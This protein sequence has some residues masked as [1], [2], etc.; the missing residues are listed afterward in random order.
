MLARDLISFDVKPLKTSDS[1]ETALTRMSDFNIRHLPI[2]NDQQLLGLVSEDDILNEDADEPVGSYGLSLNRPY[3]DEF[4]HV[5]EVLD[6]LSRFNLTAIPVID[7][8][9]KYIGLITQ[10]NLLNFL[11]NSFSFNER[12][13]I[14]VLEMSKRDYSMAEISRIV[15]S[16]HAVVLSS[17]ITNSP[18]TEHIFVTIKVNSLSIGPIISTFERF[19]YSIRATFAETTQYDTLKERY[20]S[21]MSY[22]NV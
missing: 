18:D 22:L 21:L 9:E 12:G 14:I 11:A 13:G 3:S 4:D 6:I 19:N 2:V 1:G 15:E 7:K 17:F 8:T 10:E 20:E 5:F 16:E